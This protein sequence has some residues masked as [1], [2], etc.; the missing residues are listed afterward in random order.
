[1]PPKP[2]QVPQVPQPPAQQFG[3]AL[4][5]IDPTTLAQVSGGATA[6]QYNEGNSQIYDALSGILDSLHDLAKQPQGFS[7]T[8]MLMFMMVLSR[9]RG[10]TVVAAPQPPWGFGN[11]GYYIVRR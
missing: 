5:T 2:P 8:E 1:M 7:T 11:G 10:P 6:S 3:E 9:N 4:A